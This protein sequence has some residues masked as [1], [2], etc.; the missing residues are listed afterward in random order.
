MG[1]AAPGGVPGAADAVGRMRRR[2]MKRRSALRAAIAA[3]L[4]VGI[5]GAQDPADLQ[6][7][8]A[9]LQKRLQGHEAELKAIKAENADLKAR[10]DGAASGEPTA[11]DVAINRLQDA[12]D[13]CRVTSVRS[14]ATPIT[15][16]G[17]F[18]F[19]RVSTLGDNDTLLPFK[20]PVQGEGF[21]PDLE[22]EH[23][24]HYTDARVRLN[25][26]YDFGCDITAFAELQSHWGF[27]DDETGPIDDMNGTDTDGNV[28]LY[29][30]W[31]DFR[32]MFGRPEFWSRV[33]RQEIVLGNQF[34]FGNAD[35]YN[36]VVFDGG[37]VDWDSKCWSL[38]LLGLKLSTLDGDLNQVT[39]FQ[40]G[41]DDDE[42]YGA[43]FRLKS[44]RNVAIDAYWI[45]V[46]GHGGDS[47]QG[48]VNSGANAGFGFNPALGGGGIL[49]FLYPGAEAYWHTIGARAGGCVNLF[50]GLDWN[51]EAAYQFGDVHDVVADGTDRDVDALAVEAEVGVTFDKSSRFRVFARGLYAEGPNDDGVGYLILFPNRHSYDAPFRARYGIADLIPMTNVATLQAGAHFDPF[52]D[53]TFGATLLWATTD[54][55]VGTALDDDY[56]VELDI[57]G[58]W[59]YTKNVLLGGGIAFVEP[60]DQG[61]VLWGVADDLQVIAYLDVRLWF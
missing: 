43:Y 28:H 26:R 32:N 33:G 53:W 45:Y 47:G 56:G 15:L 38:T 7:Q 18:R 30:A 17:E 16:G 9:D 59:R 42:L 39:S 61:Q 8:L 12:C 57:W 48:S 1:G 37:R 20:T 52:K 46:N 25:F 23:D 3:F 24:G 14:V 35:W 19:R 34:Q 4:V 11:L 55:A 31:V 13:P 49:G 54:E 50:C 22:E 51:V 2:S 27:G 6:R 21:G 60:D 5:G 10:M 29:Q 58:E 36:G 44:I 41:H 40:L